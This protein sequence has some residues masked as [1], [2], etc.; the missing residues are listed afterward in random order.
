MYIYWDRKTINSASTFVL[1]IIPLKKIRFP[2]VKPWIMHTWFLGH[3]PLCLF[4]VWNLHKENRKRICQCG[5]SNKHAW[6]SKL[7]SWD[8]KY[9]S[10]FRHRRRRSSNKTTFR[11]KWKQ[12]IGSWSSHQGFLQEQ[13]LPDL[14]LYTYELENYPGTPLLVPFSGGDPGLV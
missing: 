1:P 3:G 14:Y 8:K 10:K 12:W 2:F 5:L 9:G 6:Y 13:T 11:I 7:F 4:S